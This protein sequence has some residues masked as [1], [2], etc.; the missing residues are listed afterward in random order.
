M[1]NQFVRGS[2]WRRWDLHVHTASSY[3]S[4]YKGQESDQLLCDALAKN[5]I[6]AVAITD[7]FLIDHERISS[8]RTLAPNIT[9]FPG[10]ELRTDKGSRNGNLHII[11]IFSEEKDL[12]TLS[13]DFDAIMIREKA[14]ESSSNDRIYWTFEDVIDFA[15]KQ[16]ALISIHAGKKSNGVDREI[17]NGLAVNEAIKEEIARNI[18]FFEVGKFSDVAEYDI[19]IFSVIDVKPVILCSDCHDQ[20]YLLDYK[21]WQDEKMKIEGDITTENTIAF[22]E[23]ELE[24]IKDKLEI[25]YEDLCSK[26][27]KKVSE[28]FEIKQKLVSIYTDIY[29]PIEAEISKLVN[30][31]EDRIVFDAEIQLLR[32]DLAEFLL[33]NINKNYAGIFKGKIESQSKMNKLIQQTEFG[34]ID[35]ILKF[36]NSVMQVVYED[37]DASSR[38]IVDKKVF[39]DQLCAIDYIGVAFS[40]KV[41]NLDLKELS[42][43][44]R[45]IVLLIFYLALSKNSIPII[46]DQPEDNL[47]NQS[48]YSKLV[49][50][51]CAAKKKRQVVI[52]THNPNIAIA[53]DAEQ[54]IYCDIEK[55]TNFIKYESGAI[56]DGVMKK[57][58]IDVLEG[59]M[60]AFD[61][62][63]RKYLLH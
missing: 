35:S 31:L 38:K 55:S 42:P 46:I 14:K 25:S 56:E 16:Q 1:S 36:I 15:K 29:N 58:V 12:R 37:I 28:L 34:K 53:C 43:G 60:P 26:R 32:S 23:S 52:V 19:N 6:A 41:G 21:E 8:L 22:F 59:T 30:A 2:E 47:D 18:D 44:E 11:L 4:H 3:D 50:C 62:R 7:H 24:Y 20:K 39:Y 61:L 5:E 49:P 57:H 27:E 48:V 17:L 9:F 54:I 13:A 63:K 33:E 10:V 51:I 45:G 40:L